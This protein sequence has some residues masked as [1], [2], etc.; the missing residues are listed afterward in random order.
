MKIKT[1]KIKRILKDKGITLE[2][3]AAKMGLD[4]PQAAWYRVSHAKKLSTIKKI[5]RALNVSFLDI[6][7]KGGKNV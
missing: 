7:F 4:S 6:I 3:L 2:V 1:R 5:S